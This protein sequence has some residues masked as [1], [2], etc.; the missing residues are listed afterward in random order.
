MKYLSILTHKGLLRNHQFCIWPNIAPPPLRFFGQIWVPHPSQNHL[1]HPP[2]MFSEWSLTPIK[3]IAAITYG[4]WT[5]FKIMCVHWS[6]DGKHLNITT[7]P[8]QGLNLLK[9]ADRSVP[10]KQHTHQLIP[11]KEHK[12]LV[13]IIQE[14]RTHNIRSSTNKNTS[15][16]YTV[17]L[18]HVL[19]EI[20]IIC[21]LLASWKPVI[22]DCTWL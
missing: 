4:I 18:V 5:A 10:M 11:G 1:F 21:Y 3:H 16:P 12:S 2:V 8:I 22:H 15:A 14:S 13:L 19:Y 17:H 20:T 9:G 7:P 6:N